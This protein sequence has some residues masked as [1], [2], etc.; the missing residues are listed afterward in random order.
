M[1]RI[2]AIGDNARVRLILSPAALK[3]VA[4]MPKRERAGLVA[5][6]AAFADGPFAP[7]GSAKP[8][9]GLKDAVRVRHG[10]WRAVCRIDRDDGVV[11]VEAIGHRREIYR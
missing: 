9:R 5:K 1:T 8:L 11:I 3:S 4:L 7:H 6:L 10:D 2:V